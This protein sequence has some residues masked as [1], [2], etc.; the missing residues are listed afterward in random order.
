[1]KERQF[2]DYFIY[3]GKKYYSGT[4]IIV[5]ERGQNVEASFICYD[6]DQNKYIYVINDCKHYV[7]PKFFEDVLV[8][9]TDKVDGSVHMPQ[10]KQKKD[11]K[12]EGL[13]EGWVLYIVLM[14]V[15]TIFVCNVGLWILWS[16][17]FFSWRKKKIEEEGT[18][19]EW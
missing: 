14:A 10:A 6:E 9:V 5:K 12:I 7:Y 18:Y 11:M 8:E 15:S 3:N 16:Y 2:R 19:I 17:L 1:M 4:V 13:F